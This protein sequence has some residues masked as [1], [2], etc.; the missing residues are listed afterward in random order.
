MALNYS[1]ESDYDSLCLPRTFVQLMIGLHFLVLCV[2]V[3]SVY[4]RSLVTD[5]HSL[6]RNLLAAM[7]ASPLFPSF[8]ELGP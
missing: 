2:F 4:I 1:L 5:L 6:L 7:F 3:Q 8:P